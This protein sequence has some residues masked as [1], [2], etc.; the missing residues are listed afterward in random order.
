MLA[1]AAANRLPAEVPS[2]VR[3]IRDSPKTHFHRLMAAARLVVLPLRD[4]MGS[5]GQ[6]VALAAMQTAK[7]VIYTGIPVVGQYSSDGLTGQACPI[8]DV[9][10]IVELIARW[11]ENGPGAE[12]IGSAAARTA[13]DGPTRAERC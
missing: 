9:D 5:L 2:N 10:R 11:Y 8:G 12:R 13:E 4:D 3:I 7:C 6:M 1:C